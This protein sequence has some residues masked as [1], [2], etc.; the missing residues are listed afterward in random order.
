MLS[1]K[2][3]LNEINVLKYKKIMHSQ[4]NFKGERYILLSHLDIIY[5]VFRKVGRKKG[6]RAGLKEG[7]EGGR[8]GK[9][10]W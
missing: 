9:E 4:L 10:G 1:L 5:Q 6:G 8:E 2:Y 3:Y 7:S